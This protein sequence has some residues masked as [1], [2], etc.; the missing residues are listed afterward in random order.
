MHFQADAQP[1]I[2][3]LQRTQ[4]IAFACRILRK[5][6]KARLY[7]A[8]VD[9]RKQKEYRAH[10][11]AAFRQEYLN[12]PAHGVTYPIPQY[13]SDYRQKL[14]LTP[15]T[16]KEL[17]LLAD[18]VGWTPYVPVM[19]DMANRPNGGDWT[20][21]FNSCYDLRSMWGG[22]KA[23]KVLSSECE[24]FCSAVNIVNTNIYEY[25]NKNIYESI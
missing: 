17:V 7:I 16:A 13:K 14:D 21:G 8:S 3:N 19:V 24:C 20:G 10:R 15:A 6:H 23:L 18:L 25:M 2:Y 4:P 1:T 9:C 5:E 22:L 11:K 12:T